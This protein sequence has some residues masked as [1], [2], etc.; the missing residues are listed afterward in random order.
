MMVTEHRCRLCGAAPLHHVLSLGRTPLANS[1]LTEPQLG[2]PEPTFPLDLAFCGR[3][4][5]LQILETVPPERL[6]SE[7][8]YFSSFSDTMLEHSRKL[9]AALIRDR[10]LDASSLVLEIAS[11]DGY[12][13]ANYAAA[14]IP[15]LGI[16]PAKNVARTAIDRGINTRCEFFGGA[17]G[18]RLGQEGQRADVVHANNV[19]AHVPDLDGFVAGLAA[20]LKPQGIAVI[21]VPYVKD[22]MDRLEFDTIY[23][24]HL[25]YFSVTAV[26]VLMRRHGLQLRDVERVAIHGGSLRLFVTLASAS[27]TP[28]AR[29]REMI[30]AEATWGV[31]TLGPY[32][33]FAGSVR[34][35]TQAL[36]ELLTRLK[37]EGKSIAAYGAAAKGST[38]LNYAGIGRELLDFVVDR[39]PHKQGRF[40]P[41]VHL[42]ISPPERLLAAQPDYVVLLTWN[43]AAEILGQQQNFRERGG[44]FIVPLPELT[45]I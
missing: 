21:E 5:L 11:N 42:P 7:Y 19:L 39:S 45:I 12:L 28:T 3:C 13:L 41:G 15:V 36:V 38:L 8:L 9:A 44:R 20:V 33:R 4:S 6:F 43:L 23:H 22:M 1:L 10:H 29:L 14:G 27:G 31:K 24:E 26:D 32:A 35:L 2:E 34:S 37:S 17:L 18:R 16:E 40:M 30:D 25:C